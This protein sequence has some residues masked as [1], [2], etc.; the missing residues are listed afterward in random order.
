[1]IVDVNE[2]K[3][4]LIE[5]IEGNLVTVESII[6]NIRNK[7]D[8]LL[9][10]LGEGGLEERDSISFDFS[11]EEMEFIQEFAESRGIEASVFFAASSTRQISLY[12]SASASITM[13]RPFSLVQYIFPSAAVK[14]ARHG[15][16]PPGLPSHITLPFL[17]SRHVI[18]FFLLPS[19]T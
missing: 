19:K 4:N 14:E 11:K 6:K 17:G 8:Q 10:L 9:E 2:R 15:A 3:E 16:E 13:T 12:W 7:F 5:E 1:M 18:C